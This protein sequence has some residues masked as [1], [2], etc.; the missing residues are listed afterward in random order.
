VESLERRSKRRLLGEV[1][2]VAVVDRHSREGY[3][4]GYTLPHGPVVVVRSDEDLVGRVVDVRVV[5]VG[6]REVYGVPACG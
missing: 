3:Y 1:I 5:E 2:R 6:T 4:I